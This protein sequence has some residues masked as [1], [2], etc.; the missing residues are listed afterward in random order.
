MEELTFR[1]RV[2]KTNK[3]NKTNNKLRSQTMSQIIFLE[4]ENDNKSENLKNENLEKNKKLMK[5]RYKSKFGGTFSPERLE[6]L[7]LKLN[8]PISIKNSQ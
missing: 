5:K 7:I 2:N 8:R 4:K 1:N 6:G 3:K